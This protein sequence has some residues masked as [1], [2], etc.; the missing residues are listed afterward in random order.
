MGNADTVSVAECLIKQAETLSPA[1]ARR[2][3]KGC[4]LN[5]ATLGHPLDRGLSEIRENVP[6]LDLQILADMLGVCKTGDW[7]IW[8]T[9]GGLE[10]DQKDCTLPPFVWP[11]RL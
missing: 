5:A 2:A 10:S 3:E 1:A 6:A 8:L 11:V 9:K 7:E 4:A